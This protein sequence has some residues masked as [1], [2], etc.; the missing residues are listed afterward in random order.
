M[1]HEVEALKRRA[2]LITALCTGTA[3]AL[4]GGIGFVGVVVPHLLRRAFGPD[5]GLILPGSALL[6]GGL[7][8]GA[9]LFARTLAAP[10]ELPIGILTA[11][12][13]APVFLHI[14]LSRRGRP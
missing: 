12:I 14:L 13:G 5:H 10:A 4:A 1:G 3:V 6:G 9:D 11:L 2:I 7:L 8:V